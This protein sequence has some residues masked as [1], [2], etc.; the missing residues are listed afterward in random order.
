MMAGQE[1]VVLVGGPREERFWVLWNLY[2][3]W[4][5]RGGLWALCSP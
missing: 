2:G 1:I 4:H 3:P 5:P